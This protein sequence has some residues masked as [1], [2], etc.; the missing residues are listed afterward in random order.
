MTEFV[1]IDLKEWKRREYFEHYYRQVPCRFSLTVELDVTRLVQSVKK[2]G[3]MFFPRFLFIC[4]LRSLIV[5]RNSGQG[6]IPPE[7]LA[8]GDKFGQT[9]R[10]F[11]LKPGVFLR[12]GRRFPR[13]L[14]IFILIMFGI[15]KNMAR[16]RALLQNRKCRKIFLTFPVCLG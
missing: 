8:I 6:L 4:W 15:G 9:I 5:I 10:F 12:Y 11:I 2:Q 13:I 1:V 14:M 16:L 7:N 3:L